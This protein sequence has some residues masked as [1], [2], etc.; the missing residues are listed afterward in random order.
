MKRLIVGCLIAM[1]LVGCT[2]AGENKTSENVV[3]SD[4][5]NE[6]DGNGTDANGISTEVIGSEPDEVLEDDK[7]TGEDT[8][9]TENAE[10]SAE[11][12]DPLSHRGKALKMLVKKLEKI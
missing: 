2:S 11:E 4:V 7:E 12:K 10:M 5:V 8:D 1:A 6:A 9:A 3:S